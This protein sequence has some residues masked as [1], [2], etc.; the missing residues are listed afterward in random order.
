MP[1]SED[2]S[3]LAHHREQR[4]DQAEEVF[5]LAS[6]MCTALSQVDAAGMPRQDRPEPEQGH[7]CRRAAALK[8]WRLNA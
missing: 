1:S 8:F 3:W 4:R 5:A 6:P 2:V 7:I